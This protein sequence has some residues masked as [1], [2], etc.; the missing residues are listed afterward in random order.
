M[1]CSTVLCVPTLNGFVLFLNADFFKL[2][3]VSCSMLEC[4]KAVCLNLPVP[5]ISKPCYAHYKFRPSARSHPTLPETVGSALVR[6]AR[7]II[8]LFYL[9][10]QFMGSMFL[11]L[12]MW[13]YLLLWIKKHI[14]SHYIWRWAYRLLESEKQL[15]RNVKLLLQNC[16]DHQIMFT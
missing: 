2:A 1:F 12:W 4:C 15:M 8:F 5:L 13:C 3:S 6:T 10:M 7:C 16:V 14:V 9:L 11:D